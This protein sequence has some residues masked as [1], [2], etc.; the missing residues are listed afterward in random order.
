MFFFALTIE[1]QIMYTLNR[2]YYELLLFNLSPTPPK[3]RNLLQWQKGQI[4]KLLL[5]SF[6]K[7]IFICLF[8]ERGERRQKQ[9]ERNINVWLPFA[10]PLQGIW[11]ETQAWALTGNQTSDFWLAGRCSIHGA[12][13]A[14]ALASYFQCF[15]GHIISGLTLNV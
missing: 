5:A 7:K 2:C 11:P 1:Y 14:R 8:L 12:I 9:R 3:F 15:Y 6:L 13:P 4:I 10:H